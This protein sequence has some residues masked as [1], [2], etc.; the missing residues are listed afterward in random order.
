M[1][2]P[3]SD[4]VQAK[5]AA[6]RERWGWLEC[7]V[8]VIRKGGKDGVGRL[9]AV[10]AYYAF[11][12]LFPLL[13]VLVFILGKLLNGSLKDQILSSALVNFPVIGDQI[14]KGGGQLNGQGFALVFGVLT[15]LW[16][17]THA[18][19]AFDQAVH[20]VWDGSRAKQSMIKRRLRALVQLGVL[21]GALIA[22]TAATVVLNSV[23]KVPGAAVP[24]KVLM[25]M[26]LNVLF[27]L[28]LFRVVCGAE[29]GWRVHLPGAIVT[30]IG[31]TLL[32]TLGQYYLQRIVSGA[33]DTYG[34]FATVIGLLSWLHL[35]ASLLIWSAEL[36]SVMW[37][38]STRR[39]SV[40]RTHHR[41]SS[42][43]STSSTSG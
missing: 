38:R 1:R 15:A 42:T 14:T 9:A 43:S 3:G 29:R 24:A 36:S 23:V 8:S 32:Q 25:S 4:R 11:F 40:R 16:A 39:E 12:S 28:V 41:A 22:T 7:C 19:D 2:V 35:L 13:L 20:V 18:F 26:V 5:F 17:G 31:L 10:V 21:G 27:G 37:L 33:S 34:T 30:G 6:A